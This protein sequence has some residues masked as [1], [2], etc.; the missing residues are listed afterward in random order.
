MPCLCSLRR[1]VAALTVEPIVQQVPDTIP[2][3]PPPVAWARW[4]WPI[5]IATLVLDQISK[6]WL[7]AMPGARFP[8]WIELHFNPGIAWSGFGDY[9]NLVAA[10]TVVLIPVLTWVWWRWY[11]PLGRGENLAFGAILG[12]AVGNAIDRVILTPAGLSQGVR[13]FIHVDLG[14]WPFHPWPTFNIADSGITVGFAVLV[15]TGMRFR[16]HPAADAP[17]GT[18]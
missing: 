12:G 14:F 17:P 2:A 13:D 9:P 7:F 4:F 18:T 1:G 11:R 5:A 10:S 16:P 15:L 8:S 6:W 3:K